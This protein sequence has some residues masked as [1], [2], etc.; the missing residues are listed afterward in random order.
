MTKF[1]RKKL[2][3]EK[4][5]NTS[6]LLSFQI[7]FNSVTLG[8][9]SSSDQSRFSPEKHPV[10]KE[11]YVTLNEPD[12]P[13]TAGHWCGH[14][15]GQAVFF[16]ETSRVT[17]TLSL[18]NV[19]SNPGTFAFDFRLTYKVLRKVDAIVRYGPPSRPYFRGQLV[20]GTFCSLTFNSCDKSRCALQSPNF[21]GL[22][23]RNVTCYY[24]I[25]ALR[26]P[27]GHRPVI[28]LEQP[29]DHMIFVRNK[30]VSKKNAFVPGGYSESGGLSGSI[31]GSSG[32]F[33][34]SS[35]GKGRTDELTI[36]DDCDATSDHVIIYDGYTIRDPVLLKFCGGG[37]F[38]TITSS[39]NSLLM[40]FYS[41]PTDYLLQ[42]NIN[43]AI[44]VSTINHLFPLYHTH[45]SHIYSNIFIYS[46]V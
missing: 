17:L 44:Q 20:P 35:G 31:L 27:E 21:P 5:W 16:S 10:C 40:E 7:I 43:T 14:D 37:R 19:P 39:G 22:Y 46:P 34:P 28:Q 23:P 30:A 4:T 25:R 18:L 33:D 15:W 45:F 8:P 32:Q 1:R 41:A 38:P 3:E 24:A 6:C 11:G 36:G 13:A 2:H 29:K 26:S 42:N 12:R 9:P